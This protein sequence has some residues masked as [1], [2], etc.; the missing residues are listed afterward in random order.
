[1][2]IKKILFITTDEQHHKTIS[3]FG[4]KT[5]KTPHI[6]ELLRRSTIYTRAYSASPICLPSRCTW[7]TGQYPHNNNSLS[8]HFGA[9]LSNKKPNLFTRLKE[10]GFSTSLHGK[11]HFIPV[12]YPATRPDLTL[13][14]GHFKSYYESLGIDCLNLQDDKNNSLWFYDDYA[15]E[16]EK[17]GLLSIYRDAAHMSPENQGV[18]PFPLAADLHP[19]AWVGQKAVDY[20]LNSD[21][22]MHQFCWI[23]FSGP[24]YPIDAPQEYLDKVDMDKDSGRVFKENEWDDPS[25]YH[26]NGFHGPGTTEGSGCAPNR[27]QK[28][29]D[30]EY[31]KKWRKSYFG[32]VVLIDEWIGKILF[33]ARERW[34]EEFAVV[35]TSDHGEMMGNHSLWGKNGSLFEDVLRVPLAIAL[36]GQNKSKQKD[37][38]VNSVDVFP[39]LLDIAGIPVPDTIDGNSLINESY[40][41]HSFILSECE[42]RVALIVDSIKLEWNYYQRGKQLYKELYDLKIDPYEF[43]NQ[44]DNPA[45]A[46]Q[47]AT[48]EAKLHELEEQEKLLQ[49]IFYET[50]GDITTPYWFVE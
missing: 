38:L 47:K 48:L 8:N 35:F 37:M 17:K 16:L 9:S 1:M 21:K 23:S 3:A 40:T 4:A 27:A 26:Y 15:I 2:K 25:K 30:E 43:V 45:Y 11:C 13:E 32:N 12:P 41:G 6:D 10:H 44:Y 7:V 42:N 14:Y 24:H 36:P 19:D 5:H 18:F 46:K 31:W 28:N 20:I 22:D 50:M 34:G 33:A 39:T 29:Y 49:R